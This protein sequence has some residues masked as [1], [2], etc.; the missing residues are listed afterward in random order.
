MWHEIKNFFSRA[1]G[2]NWIDIATENLDNLTFES[3]IIH[4]FVLQTTIIFKCKLENIKNVN[5][6]ISYLLFF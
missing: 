2:S 3:A 5:I 1:L 6:V 4:H